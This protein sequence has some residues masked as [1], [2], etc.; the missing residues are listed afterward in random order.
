MQLIALHVDKLVSI[1]KLFALAGHLVN[2]NGTNVVVL[3]LLLQIKGFFVLVP[4]LVRLKPRLL[5]DH[6]VLLVVLRF[7]LNELLD[8]L[9]TRLSCCDTCERGSRLARHKLAQHEGRHVCLAS[10]VFKPLLN[11]ACG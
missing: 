5:S 3:N 7:Q 11:Y 8:R 1:D 4:D 9:V 6:F 2:V 10:C